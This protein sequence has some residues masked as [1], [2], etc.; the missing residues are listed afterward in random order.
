M[1]HQ[2]RTVSEAPRPLPD[3]WVTA[4]AWRIL[5]VEPDTLGEDSLKERLQRRGH[6]V[7][8]V[9][10]GSEALQVYQDVELVLLNLELPDDDGLEICR[11]IRS[12]CDVPIIAIGSRDTEPDC[13]LGLQAGADDYVIKPYRYRELMARMDAVMR[14]ARPRSASAQI[15]SH[16]RLHIDAALREVTLD[17]RRIEITR[18]E[19]DLLHALASDPGNVIPRKQLMRRIWGDSWSRRTLDTHVSSLRTKL[20]AGGWIVTV[21]GVGFRLGSG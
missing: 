8:S 1:N 6:T 3:P 10:T 4:P 12:V 16:G 11:V 14:R 13:V 21:H 17:G 7:Y 5:I 19:F 20:G 2:L 9:T 18:K 15:I